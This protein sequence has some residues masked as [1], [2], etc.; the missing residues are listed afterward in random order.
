MFVMCD[1]EQESSKACLNCR[2]MIFQWGIN[3]EYVWKMYVI[4]FK[5]GKRNMNLNCSKGL[6]SQLPHLQ[7]IKTEGK[8]PWE[9]QLHLSV[10]G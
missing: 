4:V 7:W 3:Y 10:K 9:Q 1:H 6:K 2:Q 8:I 5:L